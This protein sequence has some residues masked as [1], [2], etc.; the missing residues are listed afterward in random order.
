M[1]SALN[2][3]LSATRG[4]GWGLCKHESCACGTPIIYT[5]YSA[6]KDWPE[7]IGWAINT[8]A[9]EEEIGEDSVQWTPKKTFEERENPT[10]WR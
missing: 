3:L 5:D 4:E 6:Q 8:T 7:D 1:Y 9:S 2:V 10:K